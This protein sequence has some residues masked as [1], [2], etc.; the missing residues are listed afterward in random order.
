MSLQFD[1]QQEHA[2]VMDYEPIL[3]SSNITTCIFG[4]HSE[5]R[6]KGAMRDHDE[7][8]IKFIPRDTIAP[9]SIPYFEEK[10]STPCAFIQVAK[11]TFVKENDFMWVKGKI[12]G[13]SEYNNKEYIFEGNR[14]DSHLVYTDMQFTADKRSV[15][16]PV[17]NSGDSAIKL[18][19]GETIGTLTELNTERMIN[20]IPN[21]CKEVDVNVSSSHLST[22]YD[23][24]KNN[25][26]AK[27]KELVTN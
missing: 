22:S 15:A 27:L 23:D 6:F 11:V 20:V 10:S 8:T 14:N 17:Y 26:A 4:I 13:R 25:L 16:I 18:K 21:E 12:K 19:K 7:R 5:R 24:A 1:G 9:I 2:Y 3:I